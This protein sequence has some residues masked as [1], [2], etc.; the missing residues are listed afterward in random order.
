MIFF[1]DLVVFNLEIMVLM[2]DFFNFKG[3]LDSVASLRGGI[4]DLV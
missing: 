4:Q 2:C 3:W 1:F